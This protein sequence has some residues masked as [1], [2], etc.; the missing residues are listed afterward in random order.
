MST[1]TSP[2]LTICPVRFI[3]FDLGADLTARSRLLIR[4]YIDNH[5]DLCIREQSRKE[6]TLVGETTL[7]FALAVG[8]GRGITIDCFADGHGVVTLHDSS[9][10]VSVNDLD[11][12]EFLLA[13]RE[14]HHTLLAHEHPISAHLRQV[15]CDLRGISLPPKTQ[16][17]HT[18]SE[19]WEHNGLA[20]VMSIHF[21]AC[22]P[23]GAQEVLDVADLLEAYP[24]LRRKVGLILEPSLTG[25]E[26]T[27]SLSTQEISQSAAVRGACDDE[28]VSRHILNDAEI[29]GDHMC[30]ATWANVVICGPLSPAIVEDYT[31]IQKRVQ[32]AWFMTYCLQDALDRYVEGSQAI[33][34]DELRETRFRV[35][36][37]THRFR[38]M[39]DASLS[40]RHLQI[41]ETLM[42]TSMLVQQ[43]ADVEMKVDV[44]TERAEYERVVQESGYQQTIEMLL[45][46]LA[47][48]QT[49]GIAQ[50]LGWLQSPIGYGITAAVLM[51]A[52]LVF[53]LRRR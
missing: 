11:P 13:R 46:A 41:L 32:H 7:Q 39:A 52:I 43:I 31:F 53:W 8:T 38:K 15:L 23:D 47:F 48:L 36:M 21:L 33:G 27:P 20:Y 51:L 6:I 45:F 42:R 24:D 28:Y 30:F 22:L 29:R 5:P 40:S 44:V 25:L 4:G 9:Q 3:P 50:Q 49:V 37:T 35:R 10:T 17:R 26:D 1:V 18:A 14:A 2:H 12:W 34:L 16:A 19:A